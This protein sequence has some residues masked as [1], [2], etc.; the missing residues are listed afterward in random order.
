MSISDLRTE[1]KSLSGL[2]AATSQECDKWIN[3]GIR[4][5]DLL[6]R[7]P[8]S[9]ARQAQ[10]VQAGTYQVSFQSVCR[11]IESIWAVNITPVTNPI[12]GLVQVAGRSRIKLHV[13]PETFK[14]KHP[15]LSNED[16]GTPDEAAIAVITGADA[17]SVP[18]GLVNYDAFVETQAT[19]TRIADGSIAADGTALADYFVAGNVRGL[20]FS[21]PADHEY[22]IEIFGKWY[23]VTLTDAIPDNNWSIY[24]PDTVMAAALYKLQL[25]KY[26]NTEG[27][28]D[29]A[30]EIMSTLTQLDFDRAEEVSNHVHRMEG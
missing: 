10:L 20:I 26:R 7:F 12:T 22:M 11:V 4:H 1:F 19:G 17:L 24:Y 23:S 13:A 30:T 6:A 2:I 25:I 15:D 3:R 5:L 18:G 14:E 21:P 16:T 29:Y 27:A 8:F 9:S 28:K